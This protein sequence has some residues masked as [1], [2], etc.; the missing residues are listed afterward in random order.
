MLFSAKLEVYGPD[1]Q[2]RSSFSLARGRGR[3]RARGASPGAAV[4]N[5]ATHALELRAS[6]DRAST[7]STPRKTIAPIWSRRWAASTSRAGPTCRGSTRTRRR[8]E[9]RS[10]TTRP[11]AGTRPDIVVDRGRASF[12]QQFNRLTVQLRGAVI[13][14][15]YGT[16]VFDN[17]V[18]SNADRDFTLLEQAVR[19]K[20]EFS[21]SFLRVRRPGLQPAR[22][23]RSPRSPS[24]STAPRLASAIAP[25]SRSATRAPSCAARSASAMA[26][27]RPELRS[28]PVIDGLLIDGNLD[29]AHRRPHHAAAHRLHRRRRDDDGRVGRRL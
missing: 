16:D 24:G 8:Q 15:N 11:R 10:A 22:L 7:T 2:L 13:D 18:Q 9:Q 29:L 4:S 3:H 6:G 28:C 5:W 12:N 19:P 27:R 14:T 20:W 1:Y 25:A 23:S 17:V 21:P 26:A